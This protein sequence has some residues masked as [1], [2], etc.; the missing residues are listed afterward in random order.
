MFGS[1]GTTELLVIFL[2]VLLVFGKEKLP[3][4]ARGFGKAVKQFRSAIEEV[5]E[6]L[7]IDDRD[8]DLKG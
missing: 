3:E 4:L 7:N 1:I 2:I 6:E 5:K 8:H